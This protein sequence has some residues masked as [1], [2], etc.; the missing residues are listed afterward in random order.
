MREICSVN[1]SVKTL[2]MES[3]QKNKVIL[4]NLPRFSFLDIYWS[5]KV[6]SVRFGTKLVKIKVRY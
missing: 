4:Q 1:G 6:S 5:F 2:C 3:E